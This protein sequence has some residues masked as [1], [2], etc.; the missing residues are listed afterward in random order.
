[1]FFGDPGTGTI[2]FYHWSPG[3]GPL[4]TALNLSQLR[5]LIDTLTL[6]FRLTEDYRKLVM[7]RMAQAIFY[8]KEAIML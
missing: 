6:F 4:D 2:G 1:M 8:G 7:S 5:N 3:T